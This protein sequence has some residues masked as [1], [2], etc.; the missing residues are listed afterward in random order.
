MI[1]EMFPTKSRRFVFVDRDGVLNEYRPGDYV[2]GP[3]AL[4]VL[5]RSMAALA[6][7]AREGIEVVVISNQAGVGKGFMTTADLEEVTARLRTAIAS[8]GGRVLEF[9]YCVHRPDEGCDCRKPRPGL[10]LR[11]ARRHAFDPK[12]AWVIGDNRTD[13]EAGSNAGTRTCLVLSGKTRA[14]EE[15]SAWP[16]RPDL[17]ATDLADA[18]ARIFHLEV[19]P[20]RG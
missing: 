20:P 9:L 14:A 7:L 15:A 2:N 4:V 12:H 3:E 18:V 19:E 16:I 17:V 6:A 10:L 13:I 1:R 11:A 5:P 8:A